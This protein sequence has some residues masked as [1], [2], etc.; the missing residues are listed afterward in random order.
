MV[1]SSP[2]ARLSVRCWPWLPAIG[3]PNQLLHYVGQPT[4]CTACNADRRH[5]DNLC[6]SSISRVRGCWMRPLVLALR[7]CA[8]TE[9][10]ARINQVTY[11][12]TYRWFLLDEDAKEALLPQE[13]EG[14]LQTELVLDLVL[15]V[16]C[17]TFQVRGDPPL[18]LGRC[19]VGR[20]ARRVCVGR[21][22]AQGV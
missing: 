19:G 6:K 9:S 1:A 15:H 4:V 8:V 10:V 3:L 17:E 13:R 7:G 5:A 22:D 21:H 14:D 11:S 12:S 20:A 2:A 16:R 18:G